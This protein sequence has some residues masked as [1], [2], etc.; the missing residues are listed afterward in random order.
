MLVKRLFVSILN[1]KVDHPE[2]IHPSSKDSGFLRSIFINHSTVLKFLK[3][4]GYNVILHSYNKSKGEL[5]VKE[6]IKSLGVECKSI[7]KTFDNKQFEL[8]IFI[9]KYNLAIEY[10]GEFWHSDFNKPKNYHQKKYL[11]CQAQGINL[12]TIFEHE[13]LNKTQIIKSLIATNLNKKSIINL[14]NTQVVN[15]DKE[16]ALQFHKENHLI[17]SATNNNIGLLYKNELVTVLSLHNDE[18]FLTFKS[19]YLINDKNIFSY[20]GINKC[21]VYSDLRLNESKL[22]ENFGLEKIQEINPKII[23]SNKKFNVW[24]CGKIVY[25]YLSV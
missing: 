16:T 13:W 6:F 4:K 3:N 19:N 22:F 10:C 11:W 1:L 8:D 23:W 24:D 14:N 20:F 21:I 15:I 18:A 17:N 2:R 25:Q 5:E 7:K 9:P 12:L